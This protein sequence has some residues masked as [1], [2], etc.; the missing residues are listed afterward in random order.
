M[1]EWYGRI[2]RGDLGQSILLNRSVTAA[3]L[4]R[5]P[6]TLSLAGIALVARGPARR[7]RRHRRGGEPQPLARSG[8]HDGG[9]ARAVGAGFLARARC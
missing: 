3:I 2:L 9:P 1:V 7:R 4:E 8:R 5:L 6:V